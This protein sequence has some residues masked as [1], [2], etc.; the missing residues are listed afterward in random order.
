M[1]SEY[2]CPKCKQLHHPLR[3]CPGTE[4]EMYKRQVVK[5]KEKKVA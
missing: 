2:R 1:G 3:V 4:N 5:M